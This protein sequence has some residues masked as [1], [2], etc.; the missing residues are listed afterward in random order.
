[1]YID[2]LSLSLY[3][4]LRSLAFIFFRFRVIFWNRKYAREE[5]KE[6]EED[7]FYCF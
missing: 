4:C 7:L 2:H 5:V 6:E 3:F 1:M